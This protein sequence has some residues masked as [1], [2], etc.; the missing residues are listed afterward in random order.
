ME[1]IRPLPVTT[2]NFDEDSLFVSDKIEWVV[3]KHV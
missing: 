2:V 3:C 1:T